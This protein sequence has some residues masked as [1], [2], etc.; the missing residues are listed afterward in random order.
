MYLVQLGECPWHTS[1]S[2]G[3]PLYE[4]VSSYIYFYIIYISQL[5]D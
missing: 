3:I 2:S 1:G 5:G 4:S